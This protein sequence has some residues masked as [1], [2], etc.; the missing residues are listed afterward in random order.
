MIRM[1]AITRRGLG[2]AL[3][4]SGIAGALSA[5][6]AERPV[7]FSVGGACAD[8]TPARPMPNYYRGE[9]L[10]DPQAAPLQVHVI[11]CADGAEK[12]VIVSVDCTFLGRSEV[13]R[14]RDALRWRLGVN[15]DHVCVAA[16]HTHAAPATTASFLNGQLPDPMYLDLIVKRIGEAAEEADRRLQPARLVAAKVPV[17][18]VIACRRQ[19]SK[20][21]QAYMVG[22]EPDEACE[23]EGPVDSEMQYLIF[24][25]PAGRPLG[26]V[27]NFG[28]HNNMVSGV[29]SADFFGRIGE[30]LRARLGDIAT[31]ALAAPSG[32]VACV[33]A[34]GRKLSP[35]D[36]IMGATVANAIL[37]SY[38]EPRP[39]L[40]GRLAVRTVLRRFDDRPY[41]P[42]HFAYDNGRGAGPV[43]AAFHRAR[44][45]PEEVAVR[46]RGRTECEVE[47]QAI[48]FG[49]VALVTNPAELFSV[50]GMEIKQ[51][52]PFEVTLVSSLTNGYC[53]YVPTAEAFKHGGYETYRTVYTSRLAKDAGEQMVRE[54]IALL[55]AL[56]P[57]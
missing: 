10:P 31:V 36:R 46:T 57:P 55:Q 5:G 38:F 23:P 26:V 24:E 45:Q 27:F 12:A 4:A 40:A 17:P 56:P 13:L 54:S 11:V 47:F 29:Y 7:G 20:A 25:D 21:G 37:R 50:F 34:R 3:L 39:R 32:D 41:D 28:C 30:N 53:G 16:T 49:P 52:S 8:I 42:A 43:A 9:L 1:L 33:G 2:L 44:Y 19:V 51:G 48:S 22:S 18:P 6:T 15:P 14:I 35:D